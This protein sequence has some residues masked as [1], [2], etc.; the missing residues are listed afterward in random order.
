MEQRAVQPPASES[1][2]CAPASPALPVE[3][4]F[5]AEGRQVGGDAMGRITLL[6]AHDAPTRLGIRIALGAAVEICAEVGD[7]G[8]AIRAAKREQPEVCLVGRNIIGDGIRA[9]RGICRAVPQVSVVL[10][11]DAADPDDLLD[12]IRAGATGYLCGGGVDA[13]GL[14]RII[15]AAAEREAVVPRGMVRSLVDELRYTSRDSDGVSAREAQVLGM[16]RRGHSTSAI[17]E[18]LKITPTTVRRHISELVHKLGVDNRHAL[19]DSEPGCAVREPHAHG[20]SALRA[21]NAV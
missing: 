5:S 9:V 10:V 12:A 11:A 16:L 21:L 15:R 18:H 2:D 14:Q 20:L 13:A 7:A 17:A 19:L 1:T 4:A 3:A 8:Q 6:V